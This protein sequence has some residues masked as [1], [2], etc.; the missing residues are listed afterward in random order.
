MMEFAED[1]CKVVRVTRKIN[2]NIIKFPYTIHGYELEIVKQAKYLGV[3]ID[4]KLSDTPHGNDIFKKAATSRQFLQ[5]NLRGCSQ[6][7]RETSYHTFVR[8][9]LEYASSVWDP[10]LTNVTLTQKLEAE[11]N[12]AARFVCADW[13][14][15]SSI[16]AM[17]KHLQWES[18]QERRA[19]AR[20]SMAYRI[21]HGLVEMP[22]SFL[23]PTQSPMNTRGAPMKLIIPFSKTN[24]YQS[25]F[26][27]AASM[28]WNG[29]P[30]V[31]AG[32][33]SVDMFRSRLAAVQLC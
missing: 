13:R 18:L 12:R 26:V 23:T 15:T 27:P 8:P 21:L 22:T 28:L 14:R 25:N 16:S 9:I 29:L 33:T 2:K 1:K 4:H 11:Q 5:R 24:L 32:S 10:H 31:V 7:V 19:K 3:T 6:E 30:A 20:A 17:L